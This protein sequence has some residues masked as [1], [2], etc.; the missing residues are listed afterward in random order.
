M[1][2]NPREWQLPGVSF[3]A[4]EPALISLGCCHYSICCR[5]NQ[6]LPE[7]SGV[8]PARRPSFQASTRF[9]VAMLQIPRR[10]EGGVPTVAD[11]FP[12]DMT[13]APF[14][15]R[16]HGSEF[17]EP[18]PRQIH[19][20]QAAAGRSRAT[21]QT[22]GCHKGGAP[23]AAFALPYNRM[24]T[25]LLGRAHGGESAEPL[26]GYIFWLSRHIKSPPA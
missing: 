17:P 21:F 8:I 7:S 16:A 23:A 10:H 9:G 15:G 26:A 22:L 6:V 11:A 12:N 3:C 4:Y 13:A 24:P 5:Q 20:C 2:R 25:S 1:T 18:L 14:L 19:S